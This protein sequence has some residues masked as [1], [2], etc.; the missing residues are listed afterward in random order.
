MRTVN[1]QYRNWGDYNNPSNNERKAELPIAFWFLEEHDY[2]V[3][4]VGEVT[5]AYTS[6]PKH[7]VYDL[8]TEFPGTIMK[9][10]SEID[11][12]DQNVLSVSTLEHIGFGD[13]GHEKVESLAFQVL[14][15]ITS[16]A[17]TWC[18]TFPVGYNKELEK[19]IINS[20]LIFCLIERLS[21]STWKQTEHKNFDAYNYNNP[22]YAG[23]AI[24]VLTNEP[25]RFVFKND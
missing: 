8:I 7:I 19:D 5:N 20:D 22:Y 23:N 12:L 18:I 3:I 1:L 15:D 9:N 6:P 2:N 16:K 10:A 13:Y 25:V 17:K 4:E 14:K 21:D 11:Y 24:C